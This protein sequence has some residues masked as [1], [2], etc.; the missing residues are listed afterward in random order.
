[1]LNI[2]RND[3]RMKRALAR[4]EKWNAAFEAVR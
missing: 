3:L 4:E 1:M 2:T